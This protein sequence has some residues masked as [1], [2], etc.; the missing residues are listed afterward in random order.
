MLDQCNQIGH[1]PSRSSSKFSEHMY[2]IKKG[3][4]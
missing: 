2:E 3:D 1:W 4:E